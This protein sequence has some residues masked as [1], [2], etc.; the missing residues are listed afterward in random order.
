MNCWPKSLVYSGTTLSYLPVI[1][2]TLLCLA[3]ILNTVSLHSTLFDHC[4]IRY[5][6]GQV[7]R[8]GYVY[9]YLHSGDLLLSEN[10]A[11]FISACHPSVLGGRWR[12][13]SPPARSNRLGLPP[14]LPTA[15]LQADPARPGML[16]SGVICYHLG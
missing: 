4:T 15:P 2:Y 13:L 12:Q 8:Y 11:T 1:V 5:G 7:G 3:P 9:A 14:G 10:A 6:I 16:S